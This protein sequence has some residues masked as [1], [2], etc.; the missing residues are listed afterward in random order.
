MGMCKWCDE[1]VEGPEV[2]PGLIVSESPAPVGVSRIRRA[3][4]LGLKPADDVQKVNEVPEA[5]AA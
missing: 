4:W 3:H 2:R 1:F 5:K